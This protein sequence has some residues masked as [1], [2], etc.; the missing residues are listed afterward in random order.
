MD[1]GEMPIVNEAPLAADL[2]TVVI[3]VRDEAPRLARNF[4]SILGQKGC[5]PFEVLYVD[6]HSTD[7]S[8][9]TLLRLA[10]G[11]PNVR[12]VRLLSRERIGTVRKVAVEMARGGIIANIDSDCEAPP[13]WLA[14]CVHLAEGAAIVGFPN[15]PPPDMEYLDHRFG[16]VGD[17]QV[18]PGDLP[19]G[20]GALL[21]RAGVLAA[22]NFPEVSFGE[23]TRLFAAMAAMGGHVKLLDKP[24]M[25]M[26]SKRVTLRQHL[27][28][29]R[30]L[31]Q[32]HDWRSQR[33]Y[34]LMLLAAFVGPAGAVVAW[35]I[36]PLLAGFVLGLTLGVYVNPWKVS[37][38]CANLRR[39]SNTVIRGVVLGGIKF[40]ETW[41][42][43]VGYLSSVG[44]RR[45]PS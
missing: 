36:Q 16:Y 33:L 43:L 17:G 41:A 19:H 3:P 22:G 40:L 23:D 14:Q 10:K 15:L 42:I 13:D 21:H 4:N 45:C 34:I 24:A 27:E 31:G 26:L 8:W 9:D 28:R 29:F 12:L 35:G 1:F 44:C 7:G 30:R 5:L 18:Q 25:V 32:S 6:N 2:V 37:F 39:P 11:K 20:C 38:Y